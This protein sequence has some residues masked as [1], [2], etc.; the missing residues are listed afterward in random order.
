M[1]GAIM[2]QHIPSVGSGP[3]RVLVLHGW[4]LDSSVWQ[5]AMPAVDRNRFTYALVD[6]PGYGRDAGTPPADG[7]TVM[8]EA[9]LSAADTL[10]WDT[11]TVL[12]H[13]MGGTAALRM[14]GL[15]P[16]RVQRV[17]AVAPI[18]AGGYP[19]D[20]E[21]YGKFEAAWPD[22]GWIVRFVSP[23]L[24]EDR[25]DA[26][27]GLSARTLTKPTWD[28]YLANWTGADFAGALDGTVPTRFV[29][30]ESDPI[31]TPDH[32]AETLAALPQADVVT[33]TDAAHFP[34]VERPEA[35]VEAWERALAGSPS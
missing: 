35:A 32:L 16:A 3:T 25:A 21:S 18:G 9:A 1:K 12:G 11:F 13:S 29:L 15:V 30:G 2:N 27:T 8:A 10:G 19:V 33:V 17:C 4:A 14:A 31:A 23:G 24:V 22:V 5:W 26:L 7:M 28:R 6:F 34:M 20:E